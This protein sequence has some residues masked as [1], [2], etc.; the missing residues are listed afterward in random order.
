MKNDTPNGVLQ[1]RANDGSEWVI[2]EVCPPIPTRLL[3]YEW[4]SVDYDGP[5]DNRHGNAASE[6]ACI[7]AIEEH[8]ADA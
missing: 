8:I 1:H 3:D 4:C 7:A 2:H 5:G 6:E